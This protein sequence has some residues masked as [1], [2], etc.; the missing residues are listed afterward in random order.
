M[1][2]RTKCEPN[3]HDEN[4][5]TKSRLQDNDYHFKE[6]IYLFGWC[7]NPDIKE[8][9]IAK[10][11]HSLWGLWRRIKDY[12]HCGVWD[13]NP[14]VQ[15][16]ENYHIRCFSLFFFVFV[17]SNIKSEKFH[18]YD[19]SVSYYT[20]CISHVNAFWLIISTKP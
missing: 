17:V 18:M 6:S 8:E 10:K 1:C 13:A 7:P 11:G 19:C 15:S 3:N 16:W 4:G 2:K 5:D 9:L 12:S 14:F 20:K